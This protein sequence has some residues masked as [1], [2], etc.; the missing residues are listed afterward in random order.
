VE[1][2]FGTND[3][4]AS[5]HSDSLDLGKLAHGRIR[6]IVVPNSALRLGQCGLPK[7]IAFELYKTRLIERLMSRNH[8]DTIDEA[9]YAV[10]CQWNEVLDELIELLRRESVLLLFTSKLARA[11]VQAFEPRL[12]DG[13]SIQIHPSIAQQLGIDFSGQTVFARLP[14][15]PVGHSDAHRL[16]NSAQSFL[17][18]RDG[19]IDQSIPREAAV[20]I[21]YLTLDPSEQGECNATDETKPPLIG[22]VAELELALDAGRIGLHENLTVRLPHGKKLNEATASKRTVVTTAG[23]WLFNIQLPVELPYYNEEVR[24]PRLTQIIKFCLMQFGR[25]TAIQLVENLSKLG[26][27]ALTRSGLSLAMEDLRIPTKKERHCAEARKQA[28]KS[29]RLWHRGLLTENELYRKVVDSWCYAITRTTEDIAKELDSAAQRR[30][31][32]SMARDL[33]FL[34]GLDQVSG[35][36]RSVNLQYKTP[37]ITASFREGLRATDYFRYRLDSKSRTAAARRSRSLKRSWRL[38]SKLNDALRDTYVSMHDCGTMDGIA[39]TAIDEGIDG[40][41]FIDRIV[42]RV[43]AQRTV[44]PGSEEI[45][46]ERNQLITKEIA[47]SLERFRFDRV[48]VRS[49]VSCCAPEGICQLCYGAQ[50][51]TGILPEV[52]ER[53]GSQAALAICDAA[54]RMGEVRWYG[55]NNPWVV[56]SR[57]GD[58]EFSLARNSGRVRFDETK[59]SV[60]HAGQTVVLD[61]GFT[62]TVFDDEGRALEQVE[63]PYAAILKV[64]NDDLVQYHQYLAEWTPE[65]H[66]L[67]AEHSG[68][69]RLKHLD[70]NDHGMGG[71]Q[72]SMVV[73]RA[74]NSRVPTLE[75]VDEHGA[76]RQT[77]YLFRGTQLF[78]NEGDEVVAGDILAEWRRPIRKA[79]PKRE[80]EALPEFVATISHL[81]SL[82]NLTVPTGAAVMAE[83]DGEL[84]VTQ[85]ENGVSLKLCSM[86]GS[87]Y[88]EYLVPYSKCS[89]NF[90][91]PTWRKAVS[92]GEL[93]SRGGPGWQDTLRV[94]GTKFF[95]ERWMHD[96][97]LIHHMNRLKIAEQHLELA[98]GK[99]TS[100]FPKPRYR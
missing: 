71:V 15:S 65:V 35:M 37:L 31:L 58:S 56:Q 43:S 18:Q 73:H 27:D 34:N 50:P 11:A 41:K 84:S 2:A 92:A 19:S 22:S 96:M 46:I 63:V 61:Q 9:E 21:R 97:L 74:R 33:G 88:K 3:S 99:K 66:M 44:A 10:A 67:V 1:Q 77:R 95:V 69:V 59:C 91:A 80:I 78:V 23:R 87:K 90:Y 85:A 38:A 8:V 48:E 49:P 14:Q 57:D 81:E 94:C 75:I 64:K 25:K 60:N 30:S 76:T 93:L 45:V 39:K 98:L 26:W 12:I 53:V 4:P 51:H 68:R 54:T 5:P 13:T 86:E 52:G 72:N 7:Q 32:L 42:G 55:S 40:I 28:D 47:E 24:A 29:T 89:F 36:I 83:F 62:V 70:I 17:N 16:L 100:F 6:A 79:D 20:G 82:L